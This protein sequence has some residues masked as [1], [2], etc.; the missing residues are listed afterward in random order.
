[1][2]F[3]IGNAR[4]ITPERIIHG[5]VE[6]EGGKIKRVFAGKAPETGVVID[7][8]G[9]Y[10]APGF[11]DIHVHGKYKAQFSAGTPEVLNEATRFF[12]KHGTTAIVP[13]FGSNS[14]DVILRGV[15]NVARAMQEGNDGARVIGAHM[16]GCYFNPKCSGAQNP[17]FLFPPKPE[18]YM[19][20][21][22]TGVVLRVSASPEVEGVLDMARRLA[23]QGILMSVGHSDA[24]YED[25][26]HA[27]DAGFTH[28]T[29]IYNAISMLSN[30]YYYPAVGACETA[31]LHDEFTVEA[32]CDGRHVPPQLLRLM[33]KIK[34]PDLFHAVT[35]SVYAGAENGTRIDDA[36]LPSKIEND[37][38]V[39]ADDS[40]F[41]GSIATTDR[42]LRTLVFDAN[43]PIC[44]AVKMVTLTPARQVRALDI[45]RIA[46]GMRADLNLFGDDLQ[47]KKTW[48]G[49]REY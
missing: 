10:L 34:G 2:S 7:A 1:M 14:T 26:M 22:E 21:I 37:V 35:D 33:Y 31:L 24:N 16:E 47:I 12:G 9:D 3:T 43:I 49:G 11:V 13:T 20:M 23:P 39:L 38:C 19:P 28:V 27:L 44:D 41:D 40:T 36:A 25:M 32:I 8:G 17:A 18:N 29:H 5:G 4:V 45:G 30:C 46:E 42:L 15:K 48:I 6:I